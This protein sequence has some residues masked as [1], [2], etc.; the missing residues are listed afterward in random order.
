MPSCGS[1]I[2]KRNG[3]R[4]G[5][6]LY[7]CMACGHQF[8]AGDTMTDMGYAIRGIVIDRSLFDTFPQ[9]RIQMCQFH[10]RSIVD[11]YLTKNPAMLRLRGKDSDL[12][13]TPDT[14][15]QIFSLQF[16]PLDYNSV[17]PACILTYTPLFLP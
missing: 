15:P 17:F 11:R 8:R 16:D 14:K 7:K 6:Q 10:M 1:R 4:N 12:E 2:T 5:K 3:T 9:Y 13:Q